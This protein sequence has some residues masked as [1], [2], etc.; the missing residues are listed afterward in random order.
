MQTD[1]IYHILRE[2]KGEQMSI[3]DKDLIEEYENKTFYS[4]LIELM[5]WEESR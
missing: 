5:N 2:V 4:F 1:E 3:A